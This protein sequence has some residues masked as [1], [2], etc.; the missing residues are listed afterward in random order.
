MLKPP[1]DSRAQAPGQQLA[2]PVCTWVLGC[3]QLGF[4]SHSPSIPS[5]GSSSENT[6]YIQVQSSSA[7]LQGP[8]GPVVSG[9]GWD[10]VHFPTQ[11]PLPQEPP[12]WA[13]PGLHVGATAHQAA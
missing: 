4:R 10:R 13:V 1:R 12:N 2:G 7:E 6:A 8:L 5:P 9:E 11:R 3:T